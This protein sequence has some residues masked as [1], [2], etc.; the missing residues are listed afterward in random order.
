M[1]A[2]MP[3]SVSIELDLSGA[4]LVAVW[5]IGLASGFYSGYGYCPKDELPVVRYCSYL[6]WDNGVTVEHTNFC[7]ATKVGNEFKCFC[8]VKDEQ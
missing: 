4:T 6:L 5:L 8:G 7:E 1:G 2:G 3:K